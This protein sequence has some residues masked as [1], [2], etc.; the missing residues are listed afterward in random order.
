MEDKDSLVAA[1]QSHLQDLALRRT[2]IRDKGSLV[3][4]ER[5]PIQGMVLRRTPMARHLPNTVPRLINKVATVTAI[6]H[7]SKRLDQLDKLFRNCQ[8]NI[9]EYSRNHQRRRLQ[10]RWVKQTGGWCGY[11][12]SYG[13]LSG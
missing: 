12:S 8:I 11:N 4:A 13:H 7:R 10:K 5:I 9:L 2:L 3:A 1:S 6:H